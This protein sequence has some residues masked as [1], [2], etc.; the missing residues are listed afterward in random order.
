MKDEIAGFTQR[1]I[2]VYP[3]RRPVICRQIRSI[4]NHSAK[5]GRLPHTII[6]PCIHCICRQ[7][8][9]GVCSVCLPVG[10]RALVIADTP[11]N[12]V[13]ECRA[14]DQACSRRIIKNR[15]IEKSRSTRIN[16]RPAR[17]SRNPIRPCNSNCFH[18]FRLTVYEASVRP[19]ISFQLSD[20][21]CKRLCR[22]GSRA[23]STSSNSVGNIAQISFLCAQYDASQL[24]KIAC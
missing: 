12:Q 24:F 6:R 4:A 17:C 8:R 3:S 15:P 13:N 21:S 11:H 20:L 14:I 16:K 7:I 18:C 10:I 1:S 23:A 19:F 5:R 2:R 9:G 22:D